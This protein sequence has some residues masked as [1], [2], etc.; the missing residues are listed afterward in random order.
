MAYEAILQ[1]DGVSFVSTADLRNSTLSGT[2][3]M[4]PNGSGQFL[5]VKPSTS[6]AGVAYVTTASGQQGY[7]IVQNKPYVGEAMSIAVFGVSK[8]VAGTTTIT[9]GGDLMVDSSGCLIPYSS[10]AGQNRFAKQVGN[11]LPTAVGEVFSA[12]IY[13][14]GQGGG[15]IA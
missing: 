5:A 13:S 3:R 8:V 7:G 11:T 10:A 12:F 6:N 4:G 14:G 2:T 15:S 9:A 1:M